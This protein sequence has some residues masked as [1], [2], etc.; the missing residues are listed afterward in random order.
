[1]CAA[2]DLAGQVASGWIGAHQDSFPPIVINVSDGKATDGDPAEWAQRLRGLRTL[3]GELLLFN[4]NLSSDARK[5]ITFPSDARD[6][7]DD[8]GR[9]MFSLS[10]PA[11]R[12]H[13]E[14]TRRNAAFPPMWGPGLCLQCRHQHGDPGAR[15]RHDA[16]ANRRILTRGSGSQVIWFSAQAYSFAKEPGLPRRVGGLRRLQR[17]QRQVRDCRRSY[18]GLP[19]GRM[20]RDAHRGVCN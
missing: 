4:I 17:A 1:M 20:G 9:Q 19:L 15:R 8:Y 3:D 2:F 5:P 16:R 12:F 6:L 7:P 14:A 11:A 13:A 10:S 18:S